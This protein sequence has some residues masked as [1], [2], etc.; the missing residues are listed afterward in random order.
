VK[1]RIARTGVFLAAGA[2]GIARGAIGFRH[3][4]Y[5]A[6]V[7]TGDWIAVSSFSAFLLSLAAAFVLLARTQRRPGRWVFGCAASGAAIAGIANALEDGIGVR[8]LGYPFAAG[9]TLMMAALLLGGLWLITCQ[10]RQ[11]WVGVLCCGDVFALPLGFD[12]TG[13]LH[14]RG[15]KPVR[16]SRAAAVSTAPASESATSAIRSACMCD[17][18]AML[19]RSAEPD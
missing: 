6:P 4:A 16:P 7:T 12:T 3:P 10:P 11:P 13:P 8:A 19:R 5:W 18:S 17:V 2:L 14:V 15:V 9:V 1:N